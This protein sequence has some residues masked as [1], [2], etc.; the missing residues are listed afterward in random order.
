MSLVRRK[1]RRNVA[2]RRE[3]EVRQALECGDGS[4]T[5]IG[6]EHAAG[7]RRTGSGGLVGKRKRRLVIRGLAGI[8][9]R[10]AGAEMRPTL[11]R[12]SLARPR[13]TRGTRAARRRSAASALYRRRP[14]HSPDVSR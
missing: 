8:G 2:H 3:P 11:A 14:L 6:R 1:R 5:V 13:T 10:S 12:G 7:E 4:L 9:A